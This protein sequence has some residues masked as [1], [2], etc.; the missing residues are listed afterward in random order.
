MGQGPIFIGGLDHSGKTPMRLMLSSH[1]NIAMT[2]RTYMWTRFYGRYGD[3]SRSENLERCLAAILESKHIRALQP[4]PDRVRRE[5][6]Q[7]QL[8]Y[9]RLFALFQEHF[10][11]R[12]GKPRWGDQLAFI[13][14]Y[15]DPIFAAYPDAK[16]IH[17]I[18]DPRD[19]SKDSATTRQHRKGKAGWDTA[20]W[21]YSTGLAKRN[22]Q[23]YP[24]R[25][26]IVQ[27]EV[28]VSLTEKTLREV[29]DFLNEEFSPGM[30]AM[31]NA[32]RFGN[33]DDNGVSESQS[34]VEPRNGN[35]H[36]AMSRR[37]LAFMQTY[38]EREM[39]DWGYRLHPIRFSPAD[40]LMFRCV[41]APTNLAGMF[42]WRVWGVRQSVR[43]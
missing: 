17:M 34:S 16:M 43:S 38:A 6:R 35:S 27:Y 19:Q 1:P 5:F 3:L 2:R 14:Y 7:G 4:D 40:H 23:S 32:I 15:A 9:A 24:N 21:L 41:D 8:T 18:R 12:M 37:E 22:Q 11:E 36:K 13:E 10:A 42:A 39:M 29:C 20:R 33:N 31:E 25:Y 26:K 30:L 28:L